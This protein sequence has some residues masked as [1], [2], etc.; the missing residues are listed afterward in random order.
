[1]RDVGH[2]ALLVDVDIQ[3]VNAKVPG[4]HGTRRDD[5]VLL[6][7]VLLAEALAR[8]QRCS[9][10]DEYRGLTVSLDS[11]SWRV[12]PTSLFCHSSFLSFGAELMP[13]TSGMMGDLC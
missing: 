13:G 10:F 8:C 6:R 2:D 7:Q 9:L 5:A 3:S 12:L 1:M 4:H 11:V